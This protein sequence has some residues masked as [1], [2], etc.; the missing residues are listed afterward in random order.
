ML[1]DDLKWH[2]Q[3][4]EAGKEHIAMCGKSSLLVTFFV[5]YDIVNNLAVAD[6]DDMCVVCLKTFL[7]YRFEKLSWVDKFRK[8]AV[9][10]IFTE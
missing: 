3:S 2:I 8:L 10:D 5:P 4:P 6:L 7:F 1:V 9:C